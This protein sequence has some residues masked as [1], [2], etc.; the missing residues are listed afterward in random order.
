MRRNR[1]RVD[2][3]D[4]IV[5]RIEVRV[6]VRIEVGIVLVGNSVVFLLRRPRSVSGVFALGGRDADAVGVAEGDE[7]PP[8]F[9][10]EERAMPR[11]GGG[12]DLRA[13]A[14]QP[15]NLPRSPNRRRP[16]PRASELTRHVHP[17]T[18]RRPARVHHR[19]VP[20]PRGRGDDEHEPGP[21]L[22]DV[23]RAEF[24]FVAAET[25][26]AGDPSGSRVVLGVVRG[27]FGFGFGV[28]VG[29]GIS[30]RARLCLSRGGGAT[31]LA[32]S[33][34]APRPHGAGVVDGD[35]V[36]ASDGDADDANGGED[37]PRRASSSAAVEGGVDAGERDARGGGGIV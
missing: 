31:E 5:V 17:P 3:R 16:R 27:G 10:E 20:V 23:A 11:G 12:D 32:V 28:R 37:G 6:D 24:A 30:S 25:P 14:L 34:A 35:G 1:P 18:P 29:G 2:V 33:R 26:E 4:R 7:Y 36:V 15:P 9:V 22:V 21:G 13:D 8:P 19:R